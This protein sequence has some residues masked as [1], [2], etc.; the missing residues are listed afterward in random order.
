MCT[1]VV[2]DLYYSIFVKLIRDFKIKNCKISRLNY[3]AKKIEN[4]RSNVESGDQIMESKEDREVVIVEGRE[5]VAGG[6]Q[7][8]YKG[9]QLMLL[10]L[11]WEITISENDD[12]AILKEP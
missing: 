2:R 7:S 6:R 3:Q 12:F 8:C 5:V 1:T 11:L 10:F 9:K 4:K